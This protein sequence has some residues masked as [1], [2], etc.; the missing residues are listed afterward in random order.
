LQISIIGTTDKVTEQNWYLGNQYHV[1]QIKTSDG[2]TLTDA[3]V[4]ALVQAMATMSALPPG[5]AL[6][7]A[8]NQDQLQQPV[9]AVNW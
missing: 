9:L 4:Q 7:S 1:E 5:Q 6:L 8:A 3:N 2:H